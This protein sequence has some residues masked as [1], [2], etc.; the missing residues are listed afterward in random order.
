M[1]TSFIAGFNKTIILLSSA[2]AT[3]Y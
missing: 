2:V 3:I 1:L